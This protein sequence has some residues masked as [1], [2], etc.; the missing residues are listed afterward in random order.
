MKDVA[1]N[2]YLEQVIEQLPRGAFLNTRYKDKTNTITIGWGTIGIIW[3]KPIFM[4]AVRYSRYTY[5]LIDKSGEFTVSIPLK[6]NLKKELG[7]CGSRSG[8]DYDKFKECGLTLTEGRTVNVPII[9]E[10]QLHYECKVVYKQSMEPG[11]LDQSIKDVCYRTGDY[12]VIY[13]GEI[14]ACYMT[15]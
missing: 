10:C 5:D 14:T 12:H 3:G 13:F 9:N 7:F 11:T 6:D 8:R 4:V 2:E 15:E 1:F